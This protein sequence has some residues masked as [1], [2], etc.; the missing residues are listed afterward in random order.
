MRWNPSRLRLPGVARVG[1]RLAVLLRW[2][3]LVICGLLGVTKV[4]TRWLN[5][6]V[7]M[8]VARVDVVSI[9]GR[10]LSTT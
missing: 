6:R 2:R 4:L 8:R 10:F 1:I 9:R 3:R 7:C 5:L